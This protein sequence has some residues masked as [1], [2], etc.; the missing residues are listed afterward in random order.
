[1][2]EGKVIEANHQEDKLNQL[3]HE[4]ARTSAKIED[5]QKVIDARSH[6]L[7]NK[8]AALDETQREAGRCK[9]SINKQASENQALRRDN[10]RVAAENHDIRKECDF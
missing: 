1:M 7:R 9:D 5:I 3:E 2:S 4:F 10:E 8:I 6:D